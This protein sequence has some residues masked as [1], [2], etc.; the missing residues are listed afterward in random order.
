MACS[1][2][3]LNQ[4]IDGKRS[5][6]IS[7][8][9]QIVACIERELSGLV[10]KGA[11]GDGFVE[12]IMRRRM[13]RYRADVASWPNEPMVLSYGC[14]SQCHRGTRRG[15]PILIEQIKHKR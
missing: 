11:S 15:I 6:W 14:G 9:S 5:G 2:I 7:V 13:K 4:K 1:V 10:C 8:C 3:G 12:L